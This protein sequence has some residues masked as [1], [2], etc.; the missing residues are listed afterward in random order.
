MDGG[1]GWSARERKGKEFSEEAGF[2]EG[3]VPRGFRAKEPQSG[4]EL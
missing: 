4:R 1:G 3:R 2:R